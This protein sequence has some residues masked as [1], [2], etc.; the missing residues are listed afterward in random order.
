[1]Y[2]PGRIEVEQL[3][4]GKHPA[5]H[6]VLEYTVDPLCANQ[7]AHFSLTGQVGQRS[8]QE[9]FSMHRDEAYNFLA[10]I[11]HR[12]RHYGVPLPKASVFTRHKDY[13]QMFEDL[14]QKLNMQP[15]EPIDLERLIDGR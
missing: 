9:R 13:D 12:L 4:Y 5:L 11:D 15:G 1:M 2:V 3:A 6:L 10:E 8:V 7:H 14:R